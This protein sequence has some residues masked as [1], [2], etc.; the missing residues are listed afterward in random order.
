MMLKLI[1]MKCST[2]HVV[3]N[4]LFTLQCQGIPEDMASFHHYLFSCCHHCDTFCFT[5]TPGLEDCH[6]FVTD[7]NTT[8]ILSHNEWLAQ[9]GF[10][11]KTVC[12]CTYTMH[13][14]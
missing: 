8:V 1:A 10:L 6:L 3:L 9:H 7:V 11:S 5:V 12:T 14:T 4:F 13:Y 2:L